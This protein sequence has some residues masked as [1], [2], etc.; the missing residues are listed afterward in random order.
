MAES[1]DICIKD[2][3]WCEK[4]KRGT[5]IDRSS[6]IR[7]ITQIYDNNGELIAEK[8]PCGGYSIETIVEFSKW[9][10]VNWDKNES[11]VNLFVRW[12]NLK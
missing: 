3:I 2:V 1:V 7:I 12:T 5:E 4:E 6:P 8:D 11:V 10:I 9:L